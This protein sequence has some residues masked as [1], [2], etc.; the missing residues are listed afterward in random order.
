MA[1]G[2]CRSLGKGTSTLA[3]FGGQHHQHLSYPNARIPREKVVKGRTEQRGVV[4][5]LE[6]CRCPCLCMLTRELFKI[7]K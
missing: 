7:N 4:K 1:R 5:E 3:A 2:V 6:W